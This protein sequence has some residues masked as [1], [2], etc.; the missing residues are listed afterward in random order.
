VS[1]SAVL[2]KT[3]Q[4]DDISEVLNEYVDSFFIDSAEATIV[5]E[6]GGLSCSFNADFFGQLRITSNEVSNLR[7]DIWRIAHFANE[8][9]ERRM[10]ECASH[11]AVLASDRPLALPDDLTLEFIASDE[12]QEPSIGFP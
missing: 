9:F 3:H 10:T 8:Y 12:A 2:F 7:G 11:G 6:T 1:D 4:S 5:A